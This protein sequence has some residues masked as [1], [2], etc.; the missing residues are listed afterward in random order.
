MLPLAK[1]S[2][3]RG[4]HLAEHKEETN[5]K[6]I[7]QFAFAPVLILPLQQ[8]IGKPSIP[9]IKED[10][11]VLRGQLIAKADGHLSS[12]LHAP[13]SGSITKI[14]W[15]PHINGDMVPG[16]YLKTYAGAT[17]EVIN[18]KPCLLDEAGADDVLQAIQDA[19]I[20]GLGGAAFPTHAKLR[21]PSDK[22][23][24]TL[25]INGAE[26][27]P[28]LTTDHRVMLEQSTDVILGIRY[29]LKACGAA[30]A[31]IGIE[32]NKRNG[33]AALQQQIQTQDLQS[34]ISVELLPVKYPQGADKL[35]IKSVLG[36]ELSPGAHAYE[37]GVVTIN[38]ATAAE[39]GRL[40]PKGRGIQERIITIS[41]PAVKNKGNYRITIGTPLRFVLETVGVS[42]NLSRVFMGG[43]MMGK[44]APNLDIAITKGVSGI[45]AFTEEQLG[46]NQPQ[47]HCIHCG[48]CV[49]V[50]PMGLNPMHLGLLAMQQR[51]EEMIN[52]YHLRSCFECGTCS[53]ICPAQI[54]LVQLF[55]A[56]KKLQQTLAQKPAAKTTDT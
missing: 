49:A 37:V 16:I 56:S 31:I 50:C 13:A 10:D 14:D 5:G 27:E 22:P 51:V 33:A 47:E 36:R 18:G 44:A 6:A 32:Q 45:T 46:D 17:Q 19:G 42:E 35:L 4:I 29:A 40:L 26:C 3:A 7:R 28:Y 25:L 41:G 52:S 15:V 23:I 12:N 1:H 48:R 53:F 30:R 2:F 11:E 9:I 8:H 38:V 39:I 21:A 34:L 55:R 54:P 20:V 24:D 43:P